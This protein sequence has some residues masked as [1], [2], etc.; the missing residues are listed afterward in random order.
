MIQDDDEDPDL[1]AEMEREQ[2]DIRREEEGTDGEESD[3]SEGA[4]RKPRRKKAYS[5]SS[6]EEAAGFLLRSFIQVILRRKRHNLRSIRFMVAE[7]EFVEKE[8]QE[9]YNEDGESEH[10]DRE[11]NRDTLSEAILPMYDATME[12]LEILET[13]AF[14]REGYPKP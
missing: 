9:A 7:A 14:S 3:M 4:P 8:A 13:W 1:M 6:E 11:V 2:R 12:I 10:E 5:E